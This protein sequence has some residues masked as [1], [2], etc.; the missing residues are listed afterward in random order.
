MLCALVDCNSFLFEL[1][2]TS[3][4]CITRPMPH[5]FNSSCAA[6]G[7]FVNRC[8]VVPPRTTSHATSSQ[9]EVYTEAQLRMV[10][11]SGWHC[12]APETLKTS[13]IQ[14]SCP[15]TQL[16]PDP[17]STCTS[18][19]RFCPHSLPQPPA[20]AASDSIPDS[21]SA[22]F[23]PPS[24]LPL[25]VSTL[26]SSTSSESRRRPLRALIQR[27]CSAADSWFPSSLEASS[28]HTFKSLGHT[29]RSPGAAARVAEENKRRSH[30]AEGTRG[31][32]FVP[33]AIETYGRLGRAAVELLGEW[34][35]AAAGNGAFDRD[36]YLI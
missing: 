16:C 5:R 6:R 23:A 30:A 18:T 14:Q 33:F 21:S 36:A 35:D 26:S 27:L 20:L 22:P 29:S 1:P 3:R 10:H 31:Y 8:P 9:Q 7:T 24:P 28:G 34:A 32:R 25:S 11:L 4:T 19:E 15:S 13:Q 17:T 12:L 2:P